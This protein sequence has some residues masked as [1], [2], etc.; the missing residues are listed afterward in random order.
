MKRKIKHIFLLVEKYFK[1][2]NKKGSPCFLKIRSILLL[3]LLA[4]FIEFLFIANSVGKISF[5]DLLATIVPEKLVELTNIRRGDEGVDML[6][7]NLVLREAAQMKANDMAEKGYF[8][9][10][11]PEGLTPWYWLDKVGYDY[12][13][14]GENL[15]VNFKESHEV[16]EAWMRSPTHRDNI[17]NERFE[18]IGI[19]TAEGEYKGEEATF[20][21][22]I[23][24]T[25]AEGE[26]EVVVEEKEETE[27]V[28][29]DK[30]EEDILGEEIKKEEEY[31]ETVDTDL[32]NDDNIIIIEDDTKIEENT[33]KE[34][35]KRSSF[36]FF[37]KEKD[38]T[39]TFLIGEPRSVIKIKEEKE[40][41]SFFAKIKENQ[42]KAITYLTIIISTVFLFSFLLKFL[43]MKRIRVVYLI[44]NEVIVFCV[45][46]LAILVN[47]YVLHFFL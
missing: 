41:F 19:A 24:G 29:V 21:V 34:E 12:L 37:E 4:L 30:A 38:E 20:V 35:I 46:F 17:I 33:D 8:A 47:H 26:K 16:D 9:H 10:T 27:V 39:R 36:A 14:A 3:F 6:L 23:F 7:F 18:E 2:Y 45:I 42:G 11:S 28:F 31:K 44:V 32:S 13:Y 40:P 15:A 1:P 22:Q 43:L 25:K 5:E